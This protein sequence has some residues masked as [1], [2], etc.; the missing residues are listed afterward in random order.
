MCVCV[1]MY[2]NNIMCS[3]S[4]ISYL[5]PMQVD[6]LESQAHGSGSEHLSSFDALSGGAASASISTKESSSGTATSPEE[7]EGNHGNGSGSGSGRSPG[8][9]AAT[10]YESIKRLQ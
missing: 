8:T 3:V 10:E 7:A 1:Q 6:N 2:D 9:A 4:F 5:H